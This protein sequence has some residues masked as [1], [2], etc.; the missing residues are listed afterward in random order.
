M[1]CPSTSDCEHAQPF[2]NLVQAVSA[3][4][5]YWRGRSVHSA[6]RTIGISYP[7]VPLVVLMSER[8]PLLVRPQ[9]VDSWGMCAC[10]ESPRTEYSDFLDESNVSSATE[11]MRMQQDQIARSR[12]FLT[13]SWVQLHGIER[14]RSACAAK[15]DEN[16]EGMEQ[17]IVFWFCWTTTATLIQIQMRC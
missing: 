1:P 3:L 11:K 13:S 6:L 16:G 12:S 10:C 8:S 14:L 5:S 2:G 4:F 9:A 15:L 17:K 7:T